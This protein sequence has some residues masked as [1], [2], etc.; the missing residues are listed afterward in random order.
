M[1][2]VKSYVHFPGP[3]SLIDETLPGM[4]DRSAELFGD[5][6]ALFSAHQNVRLTFSQVKT[7]AE[8]FASG[9]LAMGLRPGDRFGILGP[10]SYEWYIGQW[11]AA[12][13]GLVMVGINSAFRANELKLCI[14]SVGI[15]GLLVAGELRGV[16]YHD[17]LASFMP[18]MLQ[19]KPREKI[20]AREVESLDLVITMSDEINLNGTF[21]FQDMLEAGTEESVTLV[22][23]LKKK[24]DDAA[25][26]LFTSGT[27][28][29][30]KGAILSHH[31]VI[32]NALATG[33]RFGWK[34]NY[35]LCAGIPL[36]HTFGCVPVSTPLSWSCVT[37]RNSFYL[38]PR[39]MRRRTSRQLKRRS[40]WPYTELP[41]CLSIC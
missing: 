26:I 19:A 30:P 6:E 31:N 39:S 15:K 18:E 36:F 38:H 32:N 25:I 14:N 21:R 27:T 24:C 7:Q 34:S 11:G 22:K 12:K 23:N 5:R 20:K 13:A 41:P 35:T 8:K 40:V 1:T 4:L 2:F 33:E 37:R 17:V 10:N 16:A 3:L 28:G 9:L 29:Q